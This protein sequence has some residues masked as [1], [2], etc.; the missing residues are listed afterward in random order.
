MGYKN[1]FYLT[2]KS[3]DSFEYF[4]ENTAS[5]FYVKLPY[6]IELEGD[7]KIGVNQI[8][9]NKMWYN[10]HSVSLQFVSNDGI[11][12]VTTPEHSVSIEDGY[13]NDIHKLLESLNSVSDIG[14]KKLCEFSYNDVTGKVCINVMDGYT[15]GI[16]KELCNMLG[17]TKTVFTKKNTGNKCVDLHMYDGFI[18]IHT[19]V[20][21]GFMYGN[22]GSDIVK[23]VCTNGYNFGEMIYD[24]YLS[25]HSRIFLKTVDVVR[26][27]VTDNT[28][29]IKQMGGVC[30]VQLHF[31]RD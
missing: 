22:S 10:L 8:W 11:N 31:K 7:W 1:E 20:V 19:N 26:I 6:T 13:Y 17:M 27:K 12:I 15:L 4:P 23:T 3:T 9:M 30:I 24:C 5:D 29:V 16:Q 21:S 18:H 14:S 2:L 25:D 28:G